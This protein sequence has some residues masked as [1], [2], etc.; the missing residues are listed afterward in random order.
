MIRIGDD[1]DNTTAGFIV[2]RNLLLSERWRIFQDNNI[3]LGT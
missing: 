1:D 3:L 2:G